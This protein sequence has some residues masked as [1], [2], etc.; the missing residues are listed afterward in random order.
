MDRG[1][2]AIKFINNLTHTKG[3]TAKAKFNLRDWQKDIVSGIFSPVNQAGNR[4]VRTAYVELP[5]KN[6]KSELAAGIALHQLI[7]DNEEGAE[8][9]SAAADR[10]QAALVF[11]VAA[12][13]VR[14]DE[15]LS[16]RLKIIDSQKRIVDYKTGSF[17]RAISSDAHTKHGFNASTVIYDEV[18]AAPNRDL[19]DVLTTS[20]GAREQPLTFAITTAGYDK[21]SLCYELHLYAEKVLDGTVIDPT[22]FPVIYS[23]QEDP[24]NPNWWLDEEVWY[25]ANPALGD[26]RGLEE[27]QIQAKR[28]REIPAA[29]NT[30]K[31]LYLN[32]WTE[33]ETR[34]I[35]GDLWARNGCKLPD[36]RGR[37]CVGALDLASTTDI[38]AF[39]LLFPKL[40]EEGN[41]YWFKCFFFVPKENIKKR[42]SRDKVPYD[43][44]LREESLIGTEGNVIDYNVIKTKI[45]ECAEMYRIREIAFDRWNSS[46]LVNDLME[47]GLNMVAFGQG[48]ASMA[49]P[50][51][52]FEKL[53]LEEGF[54]HEDNPVL[55]WMSGNVVVK[56]D[57]AGNRKPDK[58]KSTEKID[59]IVAAMMCLGRFIED[60]NDFNAGYTAT[61][62]VMAL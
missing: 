2:R 36:L 43:V 50:T 53:L 13:M 61:H 60:P 9:Y 4:I 27:M 21:Q 33:A 12:Q 25:K 19:W 38:A 39:G 47:E 7:G 26:F 58:S 35:D 42:V 23:A 48:F 37:L 28:A 1:E 8:V 56:E 15:Y 46:Q 30:F 20:M 10:D 17:Y 55:N 40:P 3:K 51:R 32:V 31:R 34:W 62:G 11:N 29:Q 24:K 49:A 59:G 45:E 14:N 54:Q 6:G 18:H 41:G 22:F 52:E 16:K 57:P 5:R 44:W